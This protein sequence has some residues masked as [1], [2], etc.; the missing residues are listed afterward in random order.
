MHSIQSPR[1]IAYIEIDNLLVMSSISAHPDWLGKPIA[2]VQRGQIIEAS[3]ELLAMGIRAGWSL[4][5]IT[6]VFPDISHLHTIEMSHLDTTAIADSLWTICVDYSPLIEPR[7]PFSCFV[8]LTGCPITALEACQDISDRSLSKLGLSIRIGLA[9]SP[10]VAQLV[11]DSRVN[12]GI[13]SLCPENEASFIAALPVDKLFMLD[14]DVIDRLVQLGIMTI[15]DVKQIPMHELLAQFGPSAPYMRDISF[16]VDRTRVQALFPHETINA[17]KSFSEPIESFPQ[18]ESLLF[19]L[20]C[21]V[22]S[23]LR[24]SSRVCRSVSIR[25]DFSS[26]SPVPFLTKRFQLSSFTRS[27]HRMKHCTCKWLIKAAVYP[28]ERMEVAV[29]DMRPES[30]TQL[31]MCRMDKAQVMSATG[32]VV[33]SISSKYGSRALFHAGQPHRER[34]E[35]LL[36]YYIQSSLHMPVSK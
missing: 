26:S 24:M 34:R 35:R 28:I 27:S 12:S 31:S 20:F 29:S 23:Q 15:G 21:E 14:S 2:V 18:L 16:G 11:C 10:L 25:V 8:D 9:S 30:G 3:H 36:D 13:T 22:E 17:G 19:N 1:T 4:R 6:A 33:D 7:L 5:Q 32:E